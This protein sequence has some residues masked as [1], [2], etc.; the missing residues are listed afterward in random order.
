MNSESKID[1]QPKSQ[2]FCKH[3][4]NCGIC[5]VTVNT[6][7]IEKTE[8]LLNAYHKVKESGVPNYIG[9][10][11][12]INHRMNIP[13]MQSLL[14]DYKD[15]KICDLL[16]F[17]FPIG[18]EGEKSDILH[19]VEKKNLWK[20]KNHKGAEDYPSEML[21]YLEKESKNAAIIGPFKDSPFP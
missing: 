14:T 7:T 1:I 9:C 3:S 20:F 5:S 8:F 15:E 19:S 11:I 10:K 18:F 16:E 4:K 6:S 2:H 13:Y 17:G 21:S 12:P